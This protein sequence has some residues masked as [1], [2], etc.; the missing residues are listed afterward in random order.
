LSY[1]EDNDAI[2]VTAFAFVTDKAQ[3]QGLKANDWVNTVISQIRGKG[4]GK[5]GLAQGSAFFPSIN[6]SSTKKSLELAAI[7]YAQSV[8]SSQ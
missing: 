5:P 4:G 7:T 6:G 8:E 3:S 1:E 2:K